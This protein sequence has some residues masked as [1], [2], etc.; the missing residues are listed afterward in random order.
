MASSHDSL[1]E[2]FKHLQFGRQSTPN[3]ITELLEARILAGELRP[4]D[5]LRETQLA[6]AFGVSRNTLRE[7][8]RVLE[9]EGLI[10]H[11]PHRGAEVTKLSEED[12]ADIYRARET[13]EVAGTHAAA[14]SPEALSAIEAE[15]DALEAAG[16]A[17]DARTLLD[18][19]FGFHRLLVAQLDSDRLDEVFGALQ[20]ELRLA[21]SQLDAYDPMPQVDEHRAIF[22]ALRAGDG[23]G[24]EELVRR[25]L[26][27]AQSR[28]AGM[29]AESAEQT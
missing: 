16:R 28:V 29:L 4:G 9:R 18:H 5:R 24:A 3:Q 2:A 14:A 23:D 6:E 13:L 15:V 1:P 26:E 11:I 22:D 8:L 27:V 20:R 19:D 10:R 21:L 7:A 12:V 25:H 17:G